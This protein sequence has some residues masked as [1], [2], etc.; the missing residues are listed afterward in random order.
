MWLYLPADRVQSLDVF[1]HVFIHV[2]AINDRIDL[3]SHLVV[4]APLPQLL[5]VFH[6]VLFPL[7]STNENID[8]LV[9][10]VT[11]DS[12]NV[13]IV[14]CR[15]MIIIIMVIICSLSPRINLHLFTVKCIMFPAMF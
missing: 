13:Q 7:T 5:E 1:I 10:A 2:E 6:M 8:F 12:K 9:E 4:S 3:E 11:G 14:T 15:K